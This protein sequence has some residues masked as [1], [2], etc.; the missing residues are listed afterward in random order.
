MGNQQTKPLKNY[1]LTILPQTT[2][3]LISNPGEAYKQQL[4]DE[5]YEVAGYG[6]KSKT[7]INSDNIRVRVYAKPDAITLLTYNVWF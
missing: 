1:A 4:V 6:L 5:K 2:L 3:P 7:H